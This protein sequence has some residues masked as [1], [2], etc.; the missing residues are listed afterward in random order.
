MTQPT[1]SGTSGHS[2]VQITKDLGLNNLGTQAAAVVHAN[3]PEACRKA[4]EAK[5]IGVLAKMG[6]SKAR[7][8]YRHAGEDGI[9]DD[10]NMRRNACTSFARVC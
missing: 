5:I 1:P 6:G 8:V 9:K 4:K 10:K 3:S 2:T 7:E